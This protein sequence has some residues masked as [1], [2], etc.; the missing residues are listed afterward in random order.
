LSA[1]ISQYFIGGMMPDSAISAQQPQTIIEIRPFRGL[2]QCYEGPGV[3]PYWTGALLAALLF[4]GSG[5]AQAKT[6]T[7]LT[8]SFFHVNS[9]IGS[10]VDG[11]T[12]IVP[13]GKATWTSKLVITKAITLMGKTTT[14][15]VA[16]TAVDQTI[17]QY[18]N[19]A[20]TPAQIYVQSVA[21][22]SYRITGL[23]FQAYPGNTVHPP[24]F[25]VLSGQSQ[26]VRVDHCDFQEMPNVDKLF[27]VGDGVY[28]VMDHNVIRLKNAQCLYLSNGN[29]GSTNSYGHATWAKPSD[30]GGP[31]F[32][33]VEDNYIRYSGGGDLIDGNAGMKV[34]VRHNHV[35]NNDFANHGTEG[36]ERGGRAMEVYAND[37]H[38]L[39]TAKNYVGG[40]RSGGIL[41]YNNN[42]SADSV[43]LAG[44]WSMAVFR[45]DVT[46]PNQRFTGWQGADGSCPWDANDT[47]GN[48]TYVAGHAPY[49]YWPKTSGSA[50]AGTGTT[51][52]QVVD[53]GSPGWSTDWFRG[54]GIR[55]MDDG[56]ISRIKDTTNGNTNLIGNPTIFNIRV[57]WAPGSPYQ[58]HRVLVALDQE[59][60]GQGDLVG[61]TANAF[62]NQVT[63]TRTWPHQVL[64]PVYAWNNHELR[65]GKY[66]GVH[67]GYPTLLANRDFYNQAGA[68]GGVQTVGVG[69]GTLANRPA[70]GVG[71]KDITGI[72][73]NPPGTAYWAT[74]VPSINGSTDKGA[75]YVWRGGAWVLY[76]QPYTYP[77]PLTRAIAPPSNLQVVP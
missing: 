77:H 76:Y 56:F 34:V 45:E 3:G 55:K 50:T 58:I 52:H 70:S 61:G 32:F 49:Q 57:Q 71:G 46:N 1:T 48:G 16:G 37:F 47:E 14:D 51:L 54:F 20:A 73:P 38:A 15:S 12:I 40:T 72:T 36:T 17:I 39:T 59:G 19:S 27:A 8:P 18:N 4:A 11:D 35:Y 13:A 68:V 64:D 69:V 9:A 67:S 6:I 74:D 2:W 62:I 41:F 7:A 26:Q 42:W 24:G 44:D 33:F 25:I 43:A 21:G 53:G 65:S 66:V 60:R 28:G 22:K 30:W 23:T 63:G 5:A 29:S 10:A 75:L 31:T